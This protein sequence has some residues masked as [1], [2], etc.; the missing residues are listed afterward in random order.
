MLLV[1]CTRKERGQYYFD[2]Q[3]EKIPQ[4]DTPNLKW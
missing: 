2:F 1:A 3:H 4:E